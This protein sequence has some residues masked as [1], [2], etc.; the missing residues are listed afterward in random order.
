MAGRQ[1]GAGSRPP[2]AGSPI[3]EAMTSEWFV[4]RDAHGR[5]AMPDPE[6]WTSP[7]DDDWRR[8]ESTTV[9]PAAAGRTNAGLP[10]RVPGQNRLPGAVPEGTAEQPEQP[11]AGP[12]AEAAPAPAPAARMSAD[13]RR[14]RYGGFQRGSQ[15][16]RIETGAGNQSAEGETGNEPTGEMT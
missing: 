7:A 13:S 8:A 16:G 5:A 12:V 4:S 6:T 2:A 3:F 9:N 15:R 1:Q 10:K 11:P 14:A